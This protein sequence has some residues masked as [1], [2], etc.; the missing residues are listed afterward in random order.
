MI[1]HIPNTITMLNLLSG[2]AAIIYASQGYIGPAV[3]LIIAGMVFDF[4]DGMAARLL[5]AY[6]DL[7]KDLDSLADV[8]TFGVAP[9]AIVFNLLSETGFPVLSSILVAGLIPVASALRLAKFNNDTTQ[10]SSF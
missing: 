2:F 6:S 9:G 4:A 3:F 8:I 7:G 1:K 10:S 5:R